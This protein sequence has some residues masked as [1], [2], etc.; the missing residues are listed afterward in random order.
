ME[1]RQHL[2]IS[3]AP[4]PATVVLFTALTIGA[5]AGYAL[6]TADR[7]SVVTPSIEGATRRVAP[8]FPAATQPPV[9]E[10]QNSYD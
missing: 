4:L 10:P 6:G 9:R 8:Q 1:A 7:W 5:I 3:V 2:R